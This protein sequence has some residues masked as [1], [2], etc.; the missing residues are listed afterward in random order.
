MLCFYCSQV[1][2]IPPIF[3]MELFGKPPWWADGACREENKAKTWALYTAHT[4][5]HFQAS[6]CKREQQRSSGNLTMGLFWKTRLF[7]GAFLYAAA[8]VNTVDTGDWR[9]E[10]SIKPPLA[11]M[12]SITLIF[13]V[14]IMNVMCSLFDPFVNG[15]KRQRSIWIY[16]ESLSTYAGEFCIIKQRMRQ[17]YSMF[18]WLLMLSSTLYWR[19]LSSRQTRGLTLSLHLLN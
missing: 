2:H 10:K 1:S 5:L 15:T 11:E 19:E 17:C 18:L 14:S 3:T 13:M 8:T 7:I 4:F 16:W 6:F 12:I 9:L